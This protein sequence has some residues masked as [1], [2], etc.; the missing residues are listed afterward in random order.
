[1]IAVRYINMLLLL[2]LLLLVLILL[3][4]L[5][6]PADQSMEDQN[7]KMEMVHNKQQQPLITVIV[8][9]WVVLVAVAVSC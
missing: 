2:L 4:L 7:H 5:H 9:S 1:M 8:T 3:S 6:L